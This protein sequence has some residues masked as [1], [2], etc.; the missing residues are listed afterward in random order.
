MRKFQIIGI[1]RGSVLG[2]KVETTKS[3]WSLHPP[4]TVFLLGES[5]DC[6][7]WW[8]DFTGN[9]VGMGSSRVQGR[10]DGRVFQGL[11]KSIGWVISEPDHNAASP[12]H[13]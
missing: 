4:P 10:G 8:D 13:L 7:Y 3:R 11:L 12:R 9:G 1:F 2:K 6:F 5:L